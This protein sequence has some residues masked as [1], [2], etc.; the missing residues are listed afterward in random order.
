M[1]ISIAKVE[2]YHTLDIAQ[3][4]SYNISIQ[5]NVHESFIVHLSIIDK[6]WTHN[7]I[8]LLGA[9]PSQLMQHKDCWKHEL[10]LVR[11]GRYVVTK[12]RNGKLITTLPFV[13]I[14]NSK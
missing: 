2:M 9:K 11:E 3:L 8:D 4:V 6:K 1:V 12:F 10:T 7:H 5:D 13:I 14:N